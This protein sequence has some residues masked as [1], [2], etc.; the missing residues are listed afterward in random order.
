MTY[1]KA[2]IILGH[3]AD[4]PTA[5]NLMRKTLRRLCRYA[6][7]IKMRSDNPFDATRPFKIKSKGH[8]PWT[9]AEVRQFENRHPLGTRPRL[10]LALLLQ[11]CQR[12]SDV[13][14]MGRQHTRDG[15]I[16]VTQ[17]KTGTQLLLPMLPELTAAIAAMPADNM[18]FLVTAYGRP[19]TAA[20]FGN[21]FRAQ[22]DAAGLPHCSA[23]GLRK[24]AMRRMAEAGFTQQQIKAW[25]GH[26]S[27]AE[28]ATY[29]R[30]ASQI[31][32]AD[33]SAPMLGGVELANLGD[34]VANSADKS[35]ITKAS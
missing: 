35:L 16:A 21:W 10:A 1:E 33:A 30:D 26:K 8:H 25:S 4:T 27:D 18:T 23:H 15:R 20:G 29:V 9:D 17:V 32:L 13:V 19:F 2:S 5:A 11:T 24:A 34:R 3:M 28:V 6:V 14:R 22:C 7:Q 31:A 12:R